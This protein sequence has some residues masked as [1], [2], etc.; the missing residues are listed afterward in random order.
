MDRGV[1]HFEQWMQI[2][3]VMLSRHDNG[4]KTG[5]STKP[6]DL[7]VVCAGAF[8]MGLVRGRWGKVEP[9]GVPLD[10]GLGAL[11]QLLAQGGALG[12]RT[13]V[14]KSLATSSLSAYFTTW[15]ATIGSRLK[16]KLPGAARV[17]TD[18]KGPTEEAS[19]RG[20]ASLNDSRVIDSVRSIIAS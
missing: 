19:S 9:F 20:W 10:L 3:D 18:P 7:L 4:P 5:A 15:G 12:R 14:A 1:E 6:D 13:R 11:L 8:A 17:A 16:F 2:V